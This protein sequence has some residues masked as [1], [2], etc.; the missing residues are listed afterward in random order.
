M[1]IKNKFIEMLQ[2]MQKVDIHTTY[3]EVLDAIKDNDCCPLCK[4]EAESVRR[5]LDSVLYEAVNDPDTRAE[6]IRSRGYCKQ[7]THT[8]AKLGNA[9]GITIIY[10]DQVKLVTQLLDNLPASLPKRSKRRQVW[11]RDESCPACHVQSECRKRYTITLLRGLS[12]EEMR[13]AYTN[14]SGLCIPHFL[15]VLG[16]TQEPEAYRYLIAQQQAKVKDLMHDLEEFHRKHDYRFTKEGFGKESDS[17]L[18]ATRLIV[19]T[20]DN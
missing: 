13:S 12:E 15:H 8:L 16:E 4:L 19:G 7:H 1:N 3:Y 20:M 10:M 2:S 17:W 14:S 5:Y 6:L 9:L 11:Q 18:R